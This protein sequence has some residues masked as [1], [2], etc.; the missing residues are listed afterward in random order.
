MERSSCRS[1][2]ARSSGV[3]GVVFMPPAS[4]RSCPFGTS[5]ATLT[6][7]RASSTAS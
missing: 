6:A 5:V 4:M 2:C 1:A 3:S 7:G